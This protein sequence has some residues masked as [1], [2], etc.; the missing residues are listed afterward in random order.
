MID[1]IKLWLEKWGRLTPLKAIR[2]NCVD[3]Q[4]GIEEGSVK[5]VRLCPNI[6]CVFWGFRM[7]RNPFLKGRYKVKQ[8]RTKSG[9]F[10]PL[11]AVKKDT[12]VSVSEGVFVSKEEWGKIK[13]KLK[14]I[15]N[16]KER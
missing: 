4:G 6:L 2:I 12:V 16:G 7:R 1:K 5:G 3:C 8:E 11:K 14:E 10:S 9:R 13:K 15:E